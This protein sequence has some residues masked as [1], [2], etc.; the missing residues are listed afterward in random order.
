[1]AG[2]RFSRI[3]DLFPLGDQEVWFGHVLLHDRCGLGGT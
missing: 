2:D 1:M 3:I